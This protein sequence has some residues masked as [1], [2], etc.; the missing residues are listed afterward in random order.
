MKRYIIFSAIAAVFLFS[1][2]VMYLVHYLIFRDTHH[3]FI[4]LVGDLA[5][6]PLE[7]LL[8]GLIID[9]LL[10]QR[11]KQALLRKLNIV[12]GAFFSEVGNQLMAELVRRSERGSEI[13][14]HFRVTNQWARHDF[15]SAKA[16]AQT[17]RIQ[18]QVDAAGLGSLKDFLRLK[19]SFM[20][21]LMENP[22]LLEHEGFTDMLL[23]V[24][25]LDEELEARPSLVG[26][27]ETDLKHISGDIE[28][29]FSR[30]ITE[31]LAYAEHLQS[32]YPFLFSLVSR[33]H[34]L[35][36]QPTPIVG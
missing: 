20:L 1:S 13:R 24:F 11:E 34:P 4:Y 5:F 25:H 17:V 36:D 19:R 9:R 12:V 15:R 14:Q 7:V 3:I 21:A 32:E 10:H 28:R 22:N 18:P 2:G 6:L 30:L 27:P 8:V 16:A 29:A 31:W 26:L 23:A 33:T 35:Q